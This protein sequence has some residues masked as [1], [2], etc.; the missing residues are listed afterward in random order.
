MQHSAF[1][2]AHLFIGLLKTPYWENN[3]LMNLMQSHFGEIL[4]KSDWYPFKSQFYTK[5]MGPT[6]DKC[7]I[8]FKNTLPLSKFWRLK[9]QSNNLENLYH[10]KNKRSFNCDPGW[11]TPYQ[12][13]LLSCKTYAH[14]IALQKGVYAEQ[15]LLFQ[16]KKAVS[17]PWTYPDYQSDYIKNCF[18]HMR[19]LCLISSC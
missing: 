12:V 19:K 18:L 1:S 7:I 17:L 4:F 6:P 14:R 10:I 2:A 15:C 9:H 8:M 3:N 16:E 5:E 11:I 13:C